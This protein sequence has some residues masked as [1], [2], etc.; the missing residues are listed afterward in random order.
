MSRLVDFDRGTYI[1]KK[2]MLSFLETVCRQDNL[3]RI[4]L[5]IILSSMWS[6]IE[7]VWGWRMAGCCLLTWCSGCIHVQL[8]I[9]P[10]L[11]Q[12]RAISGEAYLYSMIPCIGNKIYSD[13]APFWGHSHPVM[14]VSVML[15]HVHMAKAAVS[16]DQGAGI[17]I[18]QYVQCS[19]YACVGRQ[20]CTG[21]VILL[22][23]ACNNQPSHCG[24]EIYQAIV[25]RIK[26]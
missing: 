5:Y 13:S 20:P 6:K 3:R 26:R 24:D 11:C 25:C 16:P 17:D 23:P 8:F 15:M 12:M 7:R 2:K 9:I 21:K 18:L 22:V 4:L 19:M 10:Q 14:V 1:E